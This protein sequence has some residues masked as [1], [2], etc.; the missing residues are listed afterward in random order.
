MN[1]IREAMQTGFNEFVDA[2]KATPSTRLTLIEFDEWGPSFVPQAPGAIFGQTYYVPKL[3]LN[4]VYTALPINEVPKLVFHPRGS[5]PLVDAL[6]TVI[7]GTGTRLRQMP[8]NS[9]PKSILFVIIT[10]GQENAS[11][12]YKRADALQRITHQSDVYQW[13]FVYLGANQDAIAEAASYGISAGS[14]VTFGSSENASLNAMRMT[15]TKTAAYASSISGG[16]PVAASASLLNYDSKD[17]TD[18]LQNTV[19]VQPTTPASK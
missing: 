7:D 11:K 4:H 12:Q 19:V 9:R 14:T 8:P 2:H 6:C 5:T 15:G 10:D 16:A 18:A 3:D 17:R 13:Q 1:S